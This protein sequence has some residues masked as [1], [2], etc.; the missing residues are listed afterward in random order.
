MRDA[1]CFLTVLPLR[2]PAGPPAPSC[3]R[4]F[5]AAG[6]VVGAAWALTYWAVSLL[7]GPLAAAASVLCV[8]AAITGALHL[9]AVADV[10]DGVASRRPPRAAVEIMREPCVGA[11]GAAVLVLMCLLR[12][13]L[14]AVIGSHAVALIAVPVAGR[15]AMALLLVLVPPGQDASLASAFSLAGVRPAVEAVVLAT[16]LTL[17]LVVWTQSLAPLV[18]SAVALASAALYA[19]WWRARFGSLTGDGCGAGGIIA[20]TLALAALGVGLNS[21]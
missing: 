5:P 20:E 4:W 13:S 7:L 18:G 14:L 17:V 16:V 2:R 3:V 10:A 21:L 15:T 12:L 11:V 8:D 1:I 19:R 9:D 6:L